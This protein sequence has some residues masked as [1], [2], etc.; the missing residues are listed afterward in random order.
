MNITWKIDQLIVKPTEGSYTDVVITAA[1]RCSGQEEVDGKTH[2][3]SCYGTCSFGAPSDPFTPF[4]DLTEQQV[5]DWCYASGLG[6]PGPIDKDAIE[7][8]V[9]Q[10]IANSIN[11]PTVSM[12][13]P[14]NAAA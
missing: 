7:A 4:E 1:W 10:Q 2:Y 13:L 14:W 3:G 6:M 12:P 5:L 9:A 11:P 8:N